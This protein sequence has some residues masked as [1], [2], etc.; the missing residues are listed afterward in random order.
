MAGKVLSLEPA[1][2]PA[3]SLGGIKE[4]PAWEGRIRI[5]FLCD[6]DGVRQAEVRIPDHNLTPRVD[7]MLRELLE[8]IKR[9]LAGE[10][11]PPVKLA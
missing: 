1:A 10:S 8:E 9:E 4:I 11:E 7:A 2:Q 6:D 3:E 5:L